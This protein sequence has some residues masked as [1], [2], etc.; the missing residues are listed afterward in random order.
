[1]KKK[2]L[3]MK[4]VKCGKWTADEIAY[5]EA[6]FA[7]TSN[8]ELAV[9]LNRTVSSIQQKSMKMGLRKSEQYMK[10]IY[11]LRGQEPSLIPFRF[12]TGNTPFNKGKKQWQYMRG[13]SL[14]RA[15]KHQ[16]KK[17]HRPVNANPV[18]YEREDRN[19]KVYV[20]TT[21]GE[22]MRLKH[23]VVWEEANGCEVPEG[24]VVTFSDGNRQNFSPD[25]LVLVSRSELMRLVN[26]RM[27]PDQ[28]QTMREKRNAARNEAIRKDKMR[29][30]WGL[31]PKT[32]LVKKW[33]AS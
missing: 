28:K 2:I 27:T 15:R 5:L 19:G 4:T 11:K 29:I 13:E 18:G 10:K 22:R 17:G 30:R 9:I 8:K 33:Y 31:E 32:K 3:A 12:K 6:Y 20:K 24:M 23:I 16:F 21:D 26:Q 7:D 1:M 14:E 25:N